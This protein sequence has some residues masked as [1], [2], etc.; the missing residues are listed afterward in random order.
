VDTKSRIADQERRGEV[1]LVG[2][3]NE[4]IVGFGREDKRREHDEGRDVGCCTAVNAL[5]C[6]E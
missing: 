5:Q 4:V 1:M 3:E 2:T 6:E